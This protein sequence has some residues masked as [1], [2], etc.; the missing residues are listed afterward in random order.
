MKGTTKYRQPLKY[1]STREVMLPVYPNQHPACFLF[2]FHFLSLSPPRDEPENALL[3]LPFYDCP[4][5]K[6][7]P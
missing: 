4:A 2:L 6:S 5:S 7:K 1:P 3:S